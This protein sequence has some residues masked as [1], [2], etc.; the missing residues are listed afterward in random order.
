M[1][2]PKAPA[3]AALINVDMTKDFLPGGA[4]AAEDGLE[5]IPV[6]NWLGDMFETR[7]WTKE[8]HDEHHDFFASS[9]EGKTAMVDTVETE[10]G[11]QYLWPDHCV[12]GSEG[13]E[14]HEDLNVGE[15]DMIVI[16]G[17]DKTI[18]AFSAFLMDDR[19]T[20][21]TYPD[22]KTMAEKLEEAGVTK[23]FVTGLLKDFCAG[24]TAV[25]A[26]RAGFETYFVEDASKSLGLPTENGLTT[27]DVI[28]DL[29]EEAGVKV[30][31]SSQVPG[32][33]ASMSPATP[34]FN[35][36]FKPS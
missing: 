29:F 28:E 8:E 24:L 20:V 3:D 10:Y 16:K 4:L 27:I 6:I 30:I 35:K 14:F 22:G 1:N 36:G 32:I 13:T 33:L 5:I 19:K 7:V 23:V 9:H 11:T 21:I 17:T 25:D 18:H 26:A 34:G 2:L 12:I 31:D 15:D